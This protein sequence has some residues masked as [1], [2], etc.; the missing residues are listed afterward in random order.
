MVPVISLLANP[1]L[2]AIYMGGS[3]EAAESKS[4]AVCFHPNDKFGILLARV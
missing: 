1:E 3:A 4:G 2:E